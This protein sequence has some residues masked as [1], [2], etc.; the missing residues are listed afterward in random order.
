MHIKRLAKLAKEIKSTGTK[1]ILQIFHVGRMSSERTLRGIQPVSASAI[2]SLREN[3]E[4]AIALTDDEVRDVI[5]AFGEAMRRAIEAMEK[6][7]LPLLALG[8]QLLVEPNWI[9]KVKTGK[10][11]TIRTV[12][13]P[14]DEDEL[15]FPDAMWEYIQG[16]TRWVLIDK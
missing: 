14:E 4:M 13:R 11:G 6:L 2:P 8:R 12:I 10:E 3:S 16:N 9:E 7:N 5:S 15:I 1:A